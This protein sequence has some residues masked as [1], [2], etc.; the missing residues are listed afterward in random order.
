MPTEI[1]TKENI[2]FFGVAILLI[3]RIIDFFVRMK[4]KRENELEKLAFEMAKSRMNENHDL[5]ERESFFSYYLFYLD[6]LENNMQPYSD[7]AEV[8]TEF[9]KAFD[10]RIK[11]SE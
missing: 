10:T 4:K 6:A 1:F 11:R 7:Y 2:A 5:Y 9:E 3:W 8:M